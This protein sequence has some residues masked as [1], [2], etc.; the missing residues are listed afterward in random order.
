MQARTGDRGLHLL[1]LYGA[2]LPFSPRLVNSRLE[3][4]LLRLLYPNVSGPGRYTKSKA[5]FLLFSPCTIYLERARI[6]HRPRTHI[7]TD[8]HSY[9]FKR[10]TLA[11]AS[12]DAAAQLKAVRPI[13]G[14]FF[15]DKA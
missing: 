10:N 2:L 9:R 15:R 4:R 3:A 6:H 5:L 14:W 8:T 13:L 11:F 12:A 7:D 1:F